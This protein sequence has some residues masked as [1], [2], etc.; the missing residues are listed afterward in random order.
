MRLFSPY[1]RVNSYRVNSYAAL[2]VQYGFS[3]M[4]LAFVI[5]DGQNNPS[6]GGSFPANNPSG[7]DLVAMQLNAM[8]ANGGDA[9]VSFGGAVGPELA[10]VIMD[11]TTL[12]NTYQSVLGAY[13]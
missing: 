12:L 8:R 7:N 10:E 4:T 9:I 2:L 13:K 5:A 1:L 11:D 6:W 3:S